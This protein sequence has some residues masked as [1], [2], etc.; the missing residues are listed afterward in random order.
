MN[1]RAFLEIAGLATLAGRPAAAAAPLPKLALACSDYL[2]FTP[3][4][5]GDF[6]PEDLDLTWIRG[7]RSEMLR[8]AVND[9]AIQ[10]GEASMLQHLVRVDRGDRSLVAVPVFPLRN[11]T[12]RDVYVRKND[13]SSPADL[14]GRRVGV[15]SWAASGSV[16][17]RHLLRHLGVD[18]ATMTWI[19]GGV[20]APSK[21]SSVVPFPSHVRNAPADRSLV[22]LLLEG[23]VDAVFAPIPPKAFYAVDGRLAR[24][25]PEFRT[26]EKRYFE[27]T[28]CYPPQHVI[29]LRKEAWESDRS[30]GRKLVAA[31]DECEARFQAN[32]H[33]FPYGPPWLIAEV[34]ETDRL[35]G[36]DYA[37]H[38][39]EKNRAQTDAFCESAFR[40][41][42]TKQR[43]T[44]D[45]FFAE[46]LEA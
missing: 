18:P 29:V 30:V 27:Q 10:G 24:L 31:F 38:G 16:W 7:D 12:A 9:P 41:G 25:F 37:V 26:V 14:S 15:Y 22:D 20:E 2:R 33:L 35:M 32:L 28:R 11:F 19:V 42:L 6:R 4:A 3:L 40:D 8:R 44:V 13:A 43:V 46:F 45:A 39:L 36:P 23:E 34:E 5:T 17:Y 1:R 21:V